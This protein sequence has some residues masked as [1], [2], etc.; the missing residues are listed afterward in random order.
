MSDIQ[1][2]DQI[3]K[4]LKEL[5]INL[6]KTVLELE[7]DLV[8]AQ[9][10]KEIADKNL[11]DIEIQ[12]KNKKDSLT[13]T[14]NAIRTAREAGQNAAFE[15]VMQQEII[16]FDALK[17]YSPKYYEEEI[18]RD[19]ANRDYMREYDLNSI[20]KLFTNYK[21]IARFGHSSFFYGIKELLY[22]FLRR[23]NCSLEDFNNRN[24]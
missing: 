18:R 11:R 21:S 4:Q 22:G 20:E 5:E 16:L 1:S 17:E 23:Y 2:P 8:S 12:L 19:A 15:L 10:S 3:S 7:A 14:Q 9:K 6:S 13:N 24:N